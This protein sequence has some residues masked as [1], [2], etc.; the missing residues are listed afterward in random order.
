MD[1]ESKIVVF[2][3]IKD[4]SKRNAL[5]MHLMTELRD[6][7]VFSIA[8]L[9][10]YE[11]RIKKDS[12]RLVVTD[13]DFLKGNALLREGASLPER[14]Y[15]SYIVLGSYPEK[16]EYLDEVMLGKMH[17]F[18][19]EPSEEEW[20]IAFK[21]AFHFSLESKNASFQVKK[22]STGELLIHAGEIAAQV[23][24]LKRGKLE[25]FIVNE[26]N[27]RLVL[28]E[29]NPGEFVGEM[30]YFNDEPRSANVIALTECELIE[31]PLT[32]FERVLYQRPAWAMKLIDTLSKRL[33]KATGK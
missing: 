29:V 26:N 31:I 15:T 3:A 18:E 20:K 2:V 12:P 8:S 11:V 30:A 33:K 25:A 16:T 14:V 21:K 5:T 1:D 4:E 17:F 24:I 27:E 32:S 28:G 13:A 7:L 10:E 9:S 6:V 22:I 23:F 19:T